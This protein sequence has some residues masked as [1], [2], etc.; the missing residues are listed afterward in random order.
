V[1]KVSLRAGD[2]RV[3]V[4]AIARELGGGGHRA[5]AGFTTA[6]PW[7]ELVAFLRRQLSEQ[8]DAL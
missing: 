7:D 1:R 4:S 5:A 2:M 3:D 6:L 8:L